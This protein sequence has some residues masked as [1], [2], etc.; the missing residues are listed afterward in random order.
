MK[1][2]M[3]N[4]YYA[5]DYKGMV[6]MITDGSP[7]ITCARWI[8]T[9]HLN[10]NAVYVGKSDNFFYTAEGS[11]IVVHQHDL[12]IVRNVEPEELFNDICY[13]IDRF[14]EWEQHLKDCM[15]QKDGLTRMIDVSK[16]I[17]KNPS[18][19]YAPDGEMLAIASDYAPS[20]HWHWKELLDNRGLT[21]ERMQDLKQSIHL[22]E[23]FKDMFP[24]I[25]DSKMDHF[26]YMHCSI[27]TNGYMAGHFVLFSMIRPFEKGMEY[28]VN[29]LIQY[30]SKYME[31][32]Y[33]QYS[34]TSKL[35]KI[36][37]AM[38]FRQN[39]EEKEMNLFLK[40][41]R[42][43]QE[44]I[45]RFYVVKENV[46]GEPVLLTKLYK[47][48]SGMFLDAVVFILDEQLVLMENCNKRNGKYT[49][50]QQLPALLKQDFICG[51]S[52]CFCGLMQ[53]SS[54]F[55]QAEEELKYCR[56][57]ILRISHAGNHTL[58]YFGKLL[59]EN[60]VAG[61]YVH[62]SLLQLKK[63]DRENHTNYYETL[64]ALCYCGFQLSGA[65]GMLGI[66]RNSITYRLEKIREIIDFDEFDRLMEKRDLNHMNLLFLS[67]F[68]IDGIS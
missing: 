60:P 15:E 2:S 37:T 8:V 16:D 42:W 24:T 9:S 13:I 29:Q 22:T 21:E 20:T 45:Y 28:L 54:Y 50:E 56:Q 66:H 63:Y 33:S 23:V 67:F 61:T 30:M 44:D 25:R 3:W 19:V 27:I 58:E 47:K 41:L 59:H 4:L 10:E 31:Q 11:A 26:Q 39:Y 52:N 64:R 65:S 48:C 40:S 51:V 1:L 62:R 5:L 17:L 14:T 32:N 38:I 46:S 6:P 57:H 12:I 18:Y 7:T 53:C 34:P 55:H 68:F 49:I 43:K 35:G 36:V